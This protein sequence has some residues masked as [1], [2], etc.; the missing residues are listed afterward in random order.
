MDQREFFAEAAEANRYKLTEVIGK[1][2]YGVVASAVDQF[3]GG[4]L[5]QLPGLGARTLSRLA[6]RG[7]GVWMLAWQEQRT[8]VAWPYPCPLLLATGWASC[9]LSAAQLYHASMVL[10]PRQEWTDTVIYECARKLCL[11]CC[12]QAK[13]WRSRRS[14][15]C[16]TMCRVR[17][18]RGCGWAL[19]PGGK[20]RLAAA[21]SHSS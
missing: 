9:A 1:G 2:S 10:Q 4:C 21:P 13:K 6:V 7:L 16:S 3:T 14:Q 20:G 11:L 18:H 5:S 17:E 12:L 15:M 19:W 8:A